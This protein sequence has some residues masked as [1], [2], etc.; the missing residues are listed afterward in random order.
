MRL[1]RF[2]VEELSAASRDLCALAVE[3]A[4]RSPEAAQAILDL[5]DLI[6]IELLSR[7]FGNTKRARAF[8]KRY[9]GQQIAARDN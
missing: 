1:Y 7:A 5:G 6:S 2:T 8:A 4:P 9:V 3:I